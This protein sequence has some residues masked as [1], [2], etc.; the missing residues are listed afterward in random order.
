MVVD[1][2]AVAQR[3]RA[4]EAMGVVGEAEP[5]LSSCSSRRR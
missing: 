4:V 1:R 5:I 2:G 3:V